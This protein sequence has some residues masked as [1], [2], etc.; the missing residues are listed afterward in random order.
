[1]KCA[2]AIVPRQGPSPL[3]STHNAGRGK[4][5]SARRLL[6]SHAVLVEGWFVHQ[7]V[8]DRWVFSRLA[9][10]RRT[11]HAYWADMDAAAGVF[12]L[13]ATA[14]HASCADTDAAAS[15]FA[16]SAAAPHA[17]CADT[18]AAAGVFSH[19]VPPCRRPL[20]PTGTPLPGVVHVQR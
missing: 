14:P 19:S 11:A 3:A 5:A 8:R 7:Q 15:V 10:P 2:I 9:L 1:M 12:A 20:A 17:S 16:L 13:S 4:A 6:R 18:D